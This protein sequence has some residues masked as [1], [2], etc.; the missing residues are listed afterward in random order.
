MPKR[1]KK[2]PRPKDVNQL[3]HHLVR[4]STEGS[5][6]SDEAAPIPPKGL[7]AYMSALGRKGGKIGGKRR[8]DSMMETERSALGL[9][10]ATTRW[11]KERARKKRG[12]K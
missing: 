6:E 2:D 1:L 3:A 9:K 5:D 8:M 12:G 11:N 7:S 10:A 4:L